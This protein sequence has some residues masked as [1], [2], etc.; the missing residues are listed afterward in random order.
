MSTH[1]YTRTRV[2]ARTHHTKPGSACE[3]T[4]TSPATAAAQARAITGTTAP[5]QTDTHTTH[6]THAVEEPVVIDD[7]CADVTKSKLSSV[8]GKPAQ[9]SK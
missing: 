4:G 8:F 6:H 7:D 9:A 1:A 3:E 5:T 2:R